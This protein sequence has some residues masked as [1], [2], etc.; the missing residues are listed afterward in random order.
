MKKLLLLAAAMQMSVLMA[1]E[2]KIK[3]LDKAALVQALYENISWGEWEPVSKEKAE[4]ASK[5]YIDRLNGNLMQM[6]VSGNWFDTWLYN[7][8]PGKW[9]TAEEV[10][11]KLRNQNQQ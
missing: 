3:D 1:N 9:C 5:G 8:R 6:N 2:V 7:Q 10:V 4:S 11:E